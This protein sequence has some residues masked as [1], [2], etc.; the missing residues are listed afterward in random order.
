MPGLNYQIESD[1]PHWTDFL[2]KHGR[3]HGGGGGLQH[4]N[5]ITAKSKAVP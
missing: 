1:P 4:T 5:L 2:S 3:P